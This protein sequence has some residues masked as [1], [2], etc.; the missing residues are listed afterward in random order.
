MKKRFKRLL[1]TLGMTV[2]LACA[3]TTSVFAKTLSKTIEEQTKKWL[4]NDF[5]PI[6]PMKPVK[7][8][9][10]KPQKPKDHK[11]DPKPITVGNLTFE[12]EY[13]GLADIDNVTY[14][15]YALYFNMPI[16]FLDKI[17]DG[18][19]EAQARQSCMSFFFCNFDADIA[20]KVRTDPYLVYA[21]KEFDPTIQVEGGQIN[22][23]QAGQASIG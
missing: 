15:K 22:D 18:Y 6:G 12:S 3:S 7:P 19:W 1:V 16:V 5:D 11:K 17:H 23:V 2:C 10:P 21:Y 9:G 20:E 14:E 8:E 13:V 4:K